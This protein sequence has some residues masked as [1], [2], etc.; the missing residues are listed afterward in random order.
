MAKVKL[1][2]Q[3]IWSVLHKIIKDDLE[4]TE[5]PGPDQN[6]ISFGLDGLDDVEFLLLVEERFE[7]SIPD[8][9]AIMFKTLRDYFNYLKQLDLSIEEGKEEENA[10]TDDNG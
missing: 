4:F 5:K 6:L 3:Q 2:D 10:Q 7:I 1:T 9:V 8:E